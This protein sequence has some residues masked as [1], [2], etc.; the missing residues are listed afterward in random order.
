[1]AQMLALRGHEGEKT[2]RAV[3]IDVPQVGDD[4]VLV[5]V[6]AAGL[7]PGTF[8]LLE[9]GRLRP[10]PMT[11]GHE[12]AGVITATGRSV[13]D[14]T[15]GD[16][17]RIHPTLS[18]G[19]C[20]HCLTGL[21]HMCEVA[22]MMGFVALGRGMAESYPRYHNGFLAE[23]VL[24]PQHLLDRLPDNV[25]FDIGAKVHYIA[26]AVRCLKVARLPPGATIIILAPTGAMGTL[27]IRLAPYFG[28]ARMVLV[29]RSAER[30]NALRGLTE[31]ETAVVAL[32]TLEEDWKKNGGLS[33][34]V[35]QTVPEGAHAI[36]DYAPGGADL[37][38]AMDGLANG[39]MFVNMGGGFSP[40]PATMTKLV[41]RC[42]S[43]VGTRS[44]TRQDVLE[45]L[46]LLAHD[47]L[48]VDDLVTHRF[49]L[50]EI[51]AAVETIRGREQVVWMGIVNP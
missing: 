48:R 43:V 15:V 41:A 18:C 5:R 51:E 21:E 37:W 1:M 50:A 7:V 8:T 11:L 34:R 49:K 40:F 32:D 12:G 25:N 27:T 31:I 29:G 2:A 10:L 19:R 35:T 17:V 36:L 39:G 30:L 9:T 16:R 47:R 14:F 33:K 3:R 23:Y 22:A 6:M 44:N 13:R 28:V 46:Q 38:Q 45:V 24:A 42:W 20:R 26:N 4:D